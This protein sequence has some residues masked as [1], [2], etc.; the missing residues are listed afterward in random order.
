MSLKGLGFQGNAFMDAFIKARQAQDISTIRQLTAERLRQIMQLQSGYDPRWHNTTL[1]RAGARGIGSRSPL[2]AGAGGPP[3]GGQAFPPIPPTPSGGGQMRPFSGVP[4]LNYGA[5][6]DPA[7]QNF[8]VT[9][10]QTLKPGEEQFAGMSF[11]PGMGSNIGGSQPPQGAQ[12]PG[13]PHG[14]FPSFDQLMP[15]YRTSP[16]AHFI[17]WLQRRQQLNSGMSSPQGGFGGLDQYGGMPF[18]GP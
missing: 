18:G 12:P 3:G 8:G 6:G 13:A 4:P 9:M 2:A 14:G 15:G 5:Q 7:T 17:Q 16:M 1:Q 10:G 11:P